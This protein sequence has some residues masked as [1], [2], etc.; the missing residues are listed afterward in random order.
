[1][2][3]QGVLHLHGP[4]AVP[5]GSMALAWFLSSCP[6]QETQAL[7]SH[8]LEGPIYLWPA[9]KL[10]QGAR[11]LGPGSVMGPKHEEC[12]LHAEKYNT[13]MLPRVSHLTAS[14]QGEG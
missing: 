14:A 1:M 11:Y 13:C 7:R 10:S 5:A 9:G 2:F 6:R 8:V 3:A 4:D 12:A